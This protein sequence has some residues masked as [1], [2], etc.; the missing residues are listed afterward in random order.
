MFT[1]IL[2]TTI[3]AIGII[4]ILLI[5]RALRYDD[6]EIPVPIRSQYQRSVYRN[7]RR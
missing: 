1:E 7:A 5:G 2:L 4:F 6:R 3:I